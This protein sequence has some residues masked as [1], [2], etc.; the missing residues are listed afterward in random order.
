MYLK[1]SRKAK[2]ATCCIAALS[3]HTGSFNF[4]PD[5]RRG[6]PPSVHHEFYQEV[7][8]IPIPALKAE[9]AVAPAASSARMSA[10]LSNFIVPSLCRKAIAFRS[11]FSPRY[12]F[13][14]IKLPL[15]STWPGASQLTR[16]IPLLTM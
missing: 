14:H 5:A 6:N 1:F 10:L 9:A 11:I 12:P 13:Q 16:A 4:Q 15:C 8:M 2:A 7:N 3:A